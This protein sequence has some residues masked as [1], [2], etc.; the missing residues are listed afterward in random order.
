ML[1]Y[2]L[3]QY[4]LQH[5]RRRLPHWNARQCSAEEYEAHVSCTRRI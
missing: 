2:A 3:I 1:T 4:L 5:L